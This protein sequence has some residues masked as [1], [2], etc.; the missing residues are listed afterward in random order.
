MK[1]GIQDIFQGFA[2]L[3]DEQGIIKQIIRNKIISPDLLKPGETLTPVIEENSIE[4][5]FNFLHMLRT[6][7]ALYDWDINLIIEN[8]V[9]SLH[10]VGGLVENDILIVAS[11]S[12][13]QADFYY[14]ELLRMN[15]EQ[16]DLLRSSIKEKAGLENRQP[17]TD[18]HYFEEM[19]RLNNELANLQ[20]DLYKKNSQ[21][22]H[23]IKARDKYLGMAAHDFRN[24]LGGIVN[25]CEI[26]LDEDTGPL[27]SEQREFIELVQESA[28]HL[29]EVV[30]D[31]LDFSSVESGN[32]DL[33]YEVT[34]IVFLLNQAVAFNTPLA[35][36]KSITIYFTAGQSS[37]MMNIDKKKIMQVLDNL[38]S[39]AIKFSHD[40]TSITVSLTEDSESI[41]ISV[42][43]EGQGIAEDELEKLFTPFS[44]SRTSS[45]AGEKSSGLGLAICKRIVEGHH[46]SIWVESEA[47]KGSTFSFS[48]PKSGQ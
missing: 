9:H 17:S 26:L 3:C 43:D 4:K 35:R 6:E 30:N 34:D 12:K 33:R 1:E 36:R 14:S 45:T 25:S 39:N 16:T 22:Q 23:V 7:K 32:L 24:P 20:R 29:L 21:L 11:D 13:R 48:L 5:Y 40:H 8:E 2:L 19:S 15:N 28:S 37:R 46:G 18:F 42:K 31:M 27:N 41:I 44:R 47:G 38:I 10:F